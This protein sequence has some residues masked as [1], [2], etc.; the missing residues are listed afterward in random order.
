[1]LCVAATEN[2]N[3]NNNFF[4]GHFLVISS[5]TANSANISIV[6]HSSFII[7]PFAFLSEVPLAF[8]DEFREAVEDEV[9]AR[10]D[11]LGVAVGDEPFEGSLD[12][13]GVVMVE[14]VKCLGRAAGQAG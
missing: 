1:M 9:E 13:G 4:F 12:G 6:T 14:D 3:A 8:F 2:P 10:R 11:F 7:Q 5:A